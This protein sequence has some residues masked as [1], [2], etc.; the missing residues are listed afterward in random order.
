[1]KTDFR[2]ARTERA[3]IL[4]W[5]A[6]LILLYAL[7]EWLAPAPVAEEAA[8]FRAELE[9][10]R[11]EVP[12]FAGF[13]EKKTGAAVDS[14][15]AGKP[16]ER[17][18]ELFAFD[19]NTAS[20]DELL[21]LGL[22]E[23]TVGSILRY[24]ERG[25]RFR[26]KEEFGKIYTLSRTDFQRL[27]PYVQIVGAS[28]SAF[29]PKKPRRNAPLDINAAPAE[30]WAELPGIGP[31]Y[32]GR[33]V[34][35][36]EALGGFVA[37][38]QVAETFGLP[39]SVFRQIAPLLVYDGRPPRTLDP[40][41]ATEEQLEAHPYLSPSQAR[42]VVRYRERSGGFPSVDA[43]QILSPFQDSKIPFLKIKPYL[44]IQ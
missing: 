11:A 13:F 16:A 29:P 37:V 15:P 43:L 22:P 31:G 12:G 36:R 26:A 38:E 18:G 23:K 9:R 28:A 39:D 3:G 42:A 30:E 44:Q 7:P 14:P 35:F 4:I 24:R 19:P 5:T 34:R 27:L 6:L 2:V 1:M 17:V 20:A 40:N 10:M 8:D 41:R 25:G 33:I 32:A 21:R